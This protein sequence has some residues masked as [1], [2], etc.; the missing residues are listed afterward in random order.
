MR[1]LLLLFVVV[2]LVELYLLLYIGSQIG[3][4]PT[5]GIVL[6]TGALG[7]TLA[8]REGLRV[9]ANYREALSQGKLPD[10]GIVGGLLVLVGGV[11]L[12]TPGML[13]DLAGFLLLIPRTRR[14]VAD[15]IRDAIAK[16]LDTGVLQVMTHSPGGFADVDNGPA[17]PM[18]GNFASGPFEEPYGDVFVH[19]ARYDRGDVVDTEGVEV[20]QAMLL[21]NG[22]PKRDEDA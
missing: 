7:A 11:L 19:R 5:V 20:Q 16:K 1:W 10:E 22:E 15:R 9:W 2:P 12:V 4:W 17:G 14:F 13:T 3:F 21:G 6:V 8:K 18:P